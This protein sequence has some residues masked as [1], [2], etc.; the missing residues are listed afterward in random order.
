MSFYTIS[1]LFTAIASLSLALFVYQQGKD[2]APNITLALFSVALSAWCFGQFMGETVSGKEAVLFWTRC[3]L[4]AAV[5][6]PVLYL[7]FI[8]AFIERVKVNRPLLF[9]AYVAAAL[10]LLLDLTPLFVAGVA[11]RPGYRFYPVPG[12]AYPFFALYLLTLFSVGFMKL[13]AYLRRSL[14]DRRNQVK[15]VFI[16]SL[17]GFA[18]G[19]TAFFP[20]FNINLPV[21][22]QFALPLYIAI[23]VYAIVVHK[24]LDINV[25][26]REGLSYSVLTVIFAGFY[27]L[28]ILAANRLFRGLAGLNEIMTILIVVFV[29]VAVF[30]PLKNLVQ[31]L[32]DR[33]FYRGEYFYQQKIADLSAENL[34]LYRELLQADKLAALGTIA[35]GMAHEIKNPLASIK[36]LT[37]VLP[38]NLDD[39]EFISKYT[40]IVPRQ[41]DR[42]NRIV[43]DLLDFGQPKQLSM[44]EVSASKLLEDVLRLVDNQ[45]RKAEIEV[46]KEFAPVPAILADGEKLSQAFINIVLNAIQAM[47][48]GGTLKLKIKNAKVKNDEFI[49]IEVSD[50]GAGIQPERL[51]K[52]FDPFYTTKEKGTGMGLAVTYRIIK[53]HGG[54]IEVESAAGKGTIFKLCLPIKQK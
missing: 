52:I 46:V 18:G 28:M 2:K 19:A 16:G 22:S 50:T 33:L 12:A 14:G 54:T 7:H 34:K 53:E 25:V 6:V 41:L 29:S 43:E 21:V 31:G 51:P 24:L 23:A 42:I 8:L 1:L 3:N 13:T 36:G 10:F 35:A 45:C 26:I 11:P 48:G 47:A 40:E 39:K 37:Q 4:G 20:V 30:Q 9:G 17:I 44:A 5:L 49:I 15:Y 38:E 27:A 32:I